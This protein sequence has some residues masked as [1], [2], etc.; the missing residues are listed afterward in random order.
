MTA[1]APGREEISAIIADWFPGKQFLR[2]GCA[3]AI[4]ARLAAKTADEIDDDTSPFKGLNALVQYRQKEN[5]IVWHNMAA[6]DS[7]G[8]AERYRDKQ[9]ASAPW[10]YR[11]VDLSTT[12]EPKL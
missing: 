8:I 12:G 9:G 4:L 7:M 2:D 1:A 6:F 3:D 5:G 10:E 11:A